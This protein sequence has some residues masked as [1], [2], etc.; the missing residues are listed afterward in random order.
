PILPG[1]KDIERVKKLLQSTAQLEF[2][3][4]YKGEE[5]SSFLFKANETLK[6]LV[7][8]KTDAKSETK[9]AKDSTTQAEDKIKELTGE[10]A[11]DSTDVATVNPLGNLMVGGARG[12][13]VA[14]FKA[15]DKDLVMSYL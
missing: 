1:A 9:V 15:E 3:D 11:T 5:M 6:G 12:P 14:S 2:W 7:D 10:V 13:V 8:T 4:V